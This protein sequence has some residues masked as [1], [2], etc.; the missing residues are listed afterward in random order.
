VT[1]FAV[2]LKPN[3]IPFRCRV[4]VRE[5]KQTFPFSASAEKQGGQGSGPKGKAQKRVLEE[6]WV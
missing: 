5:F 1:A 6:D 3:Q 2:R 4:L